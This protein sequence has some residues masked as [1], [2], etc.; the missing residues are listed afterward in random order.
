MTRPSL[1]E[2]SRRLWDGEEWTLKSDNHPFVPLNVLEEVA[3]DVG[4]YKN[5]SNIVVVRTPEGVVML[6][7]G[8]HVA[9]MQ[10]LA[11]EKIRA[12]DARRVHTAVYTHGHVDHAYG[13]PPFL[14]EAAERGWSPPAIVGHEA[15]PA[16]MRRYIDTPGYNARIN[17]RQFG[18][19]MEWPTTAD[20]PTATYHDR[21]ELHVGGV[22]MILRHARGETDDH[23][24]ISIPGASVLV[25]GD[26]FIWAAPNC[27]NPQKV[28]RY[29]RD[30]AS[31]LREMSAEDASVLLPGHGLPIYGKDRVRQALLETATYLESLHDQTLALMNEGATIDDVIHTVKPPASLTNRPFLQPIYDEPEFI[32]RNV[33]R[34]YGG[35]YGGVPSEVKPARRAAQAREIAA[36][37]GGV[38]R[39]V[40]RAEELARAGD[41]RLACHLADWAADAEPTS[42][43]VH[44]ARARVYDARVK[45]ETSTMAKGIFRDAARGSHEIAGDEEA[46]E[47][48]RL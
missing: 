44:A 40:R 7:T 39:L 36:L 15:V 9:L 30:W 41:F 29:A 48:Q 46:I 8:S 16:R 37:A 11:F 22:R 6:D 5:F 2:M 21:M 31:S 34:C 43:E 28:Q 1:E 32:V 14:R 12:Y 13:L 4:F 23:T 27:G 33:W 35:W 25:T 10:Q 20:F 38:D 17:A 18:M 45:V 26:M 47:S 3:P 24:W 42:R 19:E